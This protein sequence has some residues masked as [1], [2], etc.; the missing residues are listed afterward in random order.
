MGDSEQP[1]PGVV[2]PKRVYCPC[3]RHLE[4]MVGGSQSSFT[5]HRI[6]LTA[7]SPCLLLTKCQAALSQVMPGLEA[8][9]FALSGGGF[10][11]EDSADWRFDP[12]ANGHSVH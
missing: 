8:S 9:G 6:V 12:W 7:F 4:Q 5:E 10:L 2:D 11:P 3:N 1:L